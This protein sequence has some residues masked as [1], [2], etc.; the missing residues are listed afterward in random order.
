MKITKKIVL[1]GCLFLGSGLL[2]WRFT[3]PTKTIISTDKLSPR[4][5]EF[6]A[7]QRSDG[8][9]LWNEVDLEKNQP[10][11]TTA[12]AVV[13]ECFSVSLPLQT[14]NPTQNFTENRCSWRAKVIEPRGYVTLASYPTTDF[15]NDSGIQLRR[16]DP[17]HYVE[18]TLSIP[19]FLE[20]ALFRSETEIMVFAL[21]DKHMITLAFTDLSRPKVVTNEQITAM[22]SKL[23]LKPVPKP[24]LSPAR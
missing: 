3:K 23:Q 11:S 9:G 6:I 4:A 5:E 18:A 1:L 14:S 19:N 10:A 15:A 16:K 21:Q 17:E 20:T 22:L 13:T 8:K 7:H 24:T 2:L 12:T